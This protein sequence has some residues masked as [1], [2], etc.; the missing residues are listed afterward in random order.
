M[1][2]CHVYFAYGRKKRL[3]TYDYGKKDP[4]NRGILYWEEEK[5]LEYPVPQPALD[6]QASSTST[7]DERSCGITFSRDSPQTWGRLEPVHE[8]DTIS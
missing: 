7:P 6:F 3:P 1:F 4:Y 8:F 5:R 2:I